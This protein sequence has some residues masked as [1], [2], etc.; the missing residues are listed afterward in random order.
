MWN[1]DNPTPH[2]DNFKALYKSI[3]FL[4]VLKEDMAYG[5]FFDNHHKSYFDLGKWQSNCLHYEAEGGALD[6]YFFAGRD[7]KSLILA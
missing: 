4:M 7:L 3:P 2:E 5:L 6:F 1:T